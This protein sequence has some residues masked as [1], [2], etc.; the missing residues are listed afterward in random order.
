MATEKL[1]TD[2]LLQLL[3]KAHHEEEVIRATIRSTM[4]IYIT[5]LV[6]IL[7][8]MITLMSIINPSINNSLLCSITLI[9]GGVI[10]ICIS[11]AAYKHYISDY[12]RQAEAIVQQA[13]LEDILGM[14]NTKNF[15]LNGY[16]QGESLLPNSFIK[17]RKMNSTS[18]EFVEWFMRYTDPGIARLLYSCFFVI[19][20]ILLSIGI[21]V[22]C[23]VISA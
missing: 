16:W 20:T 6:S 1:N 23:N 4:N 5:L 11:Y 2:Q 21:L 13:K 14:T 17:T 19:G 15:K 22:C 8:G 18:D 3:K 9:F 12:R 10:E 7:G